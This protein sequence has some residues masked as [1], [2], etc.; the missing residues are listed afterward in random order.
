MGH[1]SL[2]TSLILA[3]PVPWSRKKSVPRQTS[4][5]V[6]TED[7][8]RI[9]ADEILDRMSVGAILLSQ[10]L[11]P[12]LANRAARDL[13]GLSEVSLP[14]RLD[15]DELLSISRRSVA[16]GRPVEAEVTLWPSRASVRV[17]AIPLPESG[18]I[19][20]IL[21]DISDEVRLNQV[22]RQF[23]VNASHELKSPVAGL[24]VLAEAIENAIDDDPATAK[25]FTAKLIVET[26][27]LSRLVQD[28]LDLSRL[29]DPARFATSGVDVSALAQAQLAES[30]TAADS[31]GVELTVDAVPGTT[32]RGDPQQ[33]ALMLR[34]L[35]DNAIRHTPDGGSI[36]VRVHR[37]E[38]EA[39]VEVEDDGTGI[40]LRAQ[41]RVF[42]RFFRVDQD[43]GRDSGGTGLGLSIVKHVAEL[44]GGHVTVKSELGEGS[45]FTVRLPVAKNGPA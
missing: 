43:R 33:L 44:H 18:E 10:T 9:R 16:E 1:I 38:T 19:L 24:H 20:L 12:V 28:L 30:K 4:A 17:R 8:A 21:R 6:T 29:E 5:Q 15:S 11:T 41:A 42:E 36:Q 39:T 13:L 22:R 7:P 45:T 2:L 34:N 14:P 25:R 35:I 40:P 31:A 27:R 26:E 32:V 3:T 37:D 23:V